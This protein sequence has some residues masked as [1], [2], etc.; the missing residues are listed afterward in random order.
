[1]K[2]FLFIAAIA[3]IGFFMYYPYVSREKSCYDNVQKSYNDIGYT[4]ASR[5]LGV[6]DLC[7]KRTYALLDL[8]ECVK[9]ATGSGTVAKYSKPVIERMVSFVRPASKNLSTLKS[10]HNLECSEY[11]TYQLE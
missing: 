3:V 5:G 4:I 1:M 9:N 7:Q 11:S 10:E 8:E 2:G 6:E